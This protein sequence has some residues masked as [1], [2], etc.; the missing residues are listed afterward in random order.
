MATEDDF[1]KYL[2][3]TVKQHRK[4]ASLS[5]KELADYAGVGKTVIFDIEHAKPSVR[6]NSVIKVLIALNIDIKLIS[7][8]SLNSSE[9]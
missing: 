9:K 8:L 7:S 4:I 2:A 6:L 1:Y 3:D 5:Q